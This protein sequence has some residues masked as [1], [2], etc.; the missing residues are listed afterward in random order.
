[1][2]KT[3]KIIGISLAALVGL[4]LITLSIVLWLI[5]TPEKLT[6]IVRNQTD[7]FI[8]CTTHFDTVDITF[9]A[10]SHRRAAHQKLHLDQSHA[11]APSTLA[12]VEDLKAS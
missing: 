10:L 3:F 5:V 7:K 6:P 9:S 1:M 2:K 12:V 8:L 4:I 11:R